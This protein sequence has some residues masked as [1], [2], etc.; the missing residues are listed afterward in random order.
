MATKISR[1][2]PPIDSP[3]APVDRLDALLKHFALSARLFHSGALCG[4]VDFDERDVGY[5]HVIRS[6]LPTK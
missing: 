6:G 5:L 4:T 1:I 2:S 3:G